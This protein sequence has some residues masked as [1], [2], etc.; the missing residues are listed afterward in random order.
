MRRLLK[1]FARIG[2]Y[3]AEFRSPGLGNN[4]FNPDLIR[5]VMIDGQYSL[6]LE[7]AAYA[8]RQYSIN[9]NDYDGWLL[10]RLLRDADAP[11]RARLAEAR[12]HTW[13][14]SRTI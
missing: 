5:K 2:E 3:I 10:S 4:E 14:K 6:T 12:L 8:L 13:I 7:Q 9:H 1:T 11:L